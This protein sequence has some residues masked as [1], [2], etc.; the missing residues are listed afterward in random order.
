MGEI[1]STL[2]LVMEKTK[3][4]SLS[5]E[6]K[7]AQKNKEIEK[8]IRGLVQ[9]FEDRLIAIE[10]FKSDYQILR[11]EYGLKGTQ[12]RHL[13]TAACGRIELGKDNTMLI[14]LLAEFTNSS[15]E[16]IITVLKDFDSAL[17]AAA[18]ERTQILKDKL[19]AAHLISGSAV[20]PNL[21]SDEA[22]RQT[23]AEKRAH[24]EQLL[25]K[26]KTQLIGGA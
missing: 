14:E 15:L 4:L 6:E 25:N 3:N 18:G 10:R 23:A 11:Q 13:L 24:F 26:E 12:N 20:V 2:D 22:W 19:A 7:Q 9:K 1:K 21:E 5:S 8:R 16:G 17:Q